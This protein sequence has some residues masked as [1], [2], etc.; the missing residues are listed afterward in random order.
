MDEPKRSKKTVSPKRKRVHAEPEVESPLVESKSS[1]CTV[2][3]TLATVITEEP[4]IVVPVVEQKTIIY[5]RS[6]EPFKKRFKMA[7]MSAVNDYPSSIVI[8]TL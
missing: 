2:S 3:S 6:F 1:D 5:N 4:V 8:C 7:P